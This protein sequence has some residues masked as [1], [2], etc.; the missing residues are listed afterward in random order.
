[1]S[2]EELALNN[3]TFRPTT[4]QYMSQSKSY[5]RQFSGKEELSMTSKTGGSSLKA[6][7]GKVIAE[8][9]VTLEVRLES[10]KKERITLHKGESLND[11]VKKFSSKHN[12]NKD[13]QM[14][15]KNLV[16]SK[17]CDLA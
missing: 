15:L 9:N 5:S 13:T 6:K 8:K 7:S 10:N 12:L 14:L 17:L 2:S 1:M 3:C 16:E 11:I 4:T